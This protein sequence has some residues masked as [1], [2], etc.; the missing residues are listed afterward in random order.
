MRKLGNLMITDRGC[1]A[2]TPGIGDIAYVKDLMTEKIVTTTFACSVFG[3]AKSDTIYK[4]GW[5]C[6][7][8][9][10]LVNNS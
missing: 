1:D 3:D 4:S 8:V 6:I 7:I 10:K 2:R 9:Q 5:V